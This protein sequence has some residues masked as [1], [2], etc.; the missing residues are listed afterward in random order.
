VNLRPR[1]AIACALLLLAP[2][3]LS[4][5]ELVVNLDV[6]EVEAGPPDGCAICTALGD[7]GEDAAEDGGAPDAAADATVIDAS[8]VDAG[9]IDAGAD[10]DATP[11]TDA[12]LDSAEDG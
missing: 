9:S 4:Q 3:A 5:C 6:E 12:A 10:V 1:S 8:T 11:T 2:L 7:A